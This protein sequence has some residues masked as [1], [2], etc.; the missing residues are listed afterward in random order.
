MLMDGE[1]I[2]SGS[3]NRQHITSGDPVLGEV[4]SDSKGQQPQGIN[5]MMESKN[6]GN[7]FQEQL[8]EASQR[9]RNAQIAMM[10]SGGAREKMELQIAQQAFQTAHTLAIQFDASAP[11]PSF[12]AAS[13][14]VSDSGY[15]TD[16]SQ[17]VSSASENRRRHP[18]ARRLSKRERNK[19][20]ATKYRQKKKLYVTELEN[21]C[22]TLIRNVETLKTAVTSLQSENKLLKE[23][24]GFLKQ[25]LQQRSNGGR[26][27]ITANSTLSSGTTGMNR[28]SGFGGGGGGGGGGNLMSQPTPFASGFNSVPTPS[29][30]GSM[31]DGFDLGV[32]GGS[33]TGG[34]FSFLNEANDAPGTK[35]IDMDLGL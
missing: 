33:P 26:N 23:Q 30:L 16:S 12:P 19:I 28:G 27:G 5:P 35:E 32:G 11:S 4:V 7:P 8:N 29:D 17:S 31:G 20:S 1:D 24:M 10:R 15:D 3:E 14:R 25:L 9:L 22:T 34:D 13:R 18:Y 21:K 6:D 2:F